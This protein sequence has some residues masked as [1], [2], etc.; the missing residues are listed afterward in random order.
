LGWVVLLAIL[1]RWPDLSPFLQRLPFYITYCQNY[2]H[3]IWPD[4]VRIKGLGHLWSLAIEEQFYLFWPFMVWL[5]PVRRIWIVAVFGLIFSLVLRIWMPAYPGMYV[6]TPMRLDGLMA[7]SLLAIL[8]Y[9]FP[10]KI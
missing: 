3:I 7:G 9:I 10:E 1:F 8:Y 6:F 4:A 2:F 5:I